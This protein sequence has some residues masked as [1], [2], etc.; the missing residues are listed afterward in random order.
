MTGEKANIN[1]VVIS[2]NTIGVI[3]MDKTIDKASEC[4]NCGL[5]YKI[6]PVKVNPKRVMDTKK[7][8]KNCLDC[9]LCT[10][11]CPCHINLRK[12]L[13]GEHE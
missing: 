13:R 9:G 1:D 6:C 4:N 12:Y 7:I 10:Y 11:I 8:S 2:N 5:C 3:I